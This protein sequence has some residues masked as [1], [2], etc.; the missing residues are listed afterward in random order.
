M[1]VSKPLAVVGS[2]AV[3]AGLL[4]GT[5]I[6]PALVGASSHREA[7]GI[8]R[9]PSAD[10]TD[11]YFFVSPDK[12]NTATIIA[13]YIPLQD[14][15]GGPNFFAFD[16]NVLYSINIDNKGDAEDHIQYQFS[17][18]TELTNPKTFLYN[19]GQLTSPSDPDWTMPQTYKVTRVENG[20]S[21]VVGWDLTV[22]PNNVGSR[23]T[24][25]VT[26]FAHSTCTALPCR[27]QS[28][29]SRAITRCPPALATPT[30]SSASTPAPAAVRRLCCAR[31]A[32]TAGRESGSRFRAWASR[33]STKSSSRW[34]RRTSGIGPSRVTTGRGSSIST[35]HRSSRVS[36]ISCIQDF[37]M[38]RPPTAATCR[39][40]CSP[41][42]Q[43]STDRPTWSSRTSCG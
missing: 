26:R 5:M 2:L 3:T 20:K 30:R 36:S 17:F 23:R 35:S 19:T 25:G 1:N 22:P 13:N 18:T 33:S 6:A 28:L 4:A 39:R 10:S 16:D 7:P 12:P 42:S 43:A 27:C 40:S 38:C 31:T 11:L 14:P 34:A 37:L 32:T 15:A 8:S 21:K 41:A 24:L 29:T 9:D